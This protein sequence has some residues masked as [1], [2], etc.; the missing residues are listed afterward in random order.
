MMV[1][2]L[3]LLQ[4][5]TLESWGFLDSLNSFIL[6]LYICMFNVSSLTVSSLFIHHKKEIEIIG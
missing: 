1:G 6:Q 3:V 2:Q 4:G 5:R